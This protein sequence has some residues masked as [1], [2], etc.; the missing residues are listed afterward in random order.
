MTQIY[1]D[2]NNPN[3]GIEMSPNVVYSAQQPSE[4]NMKKNQVYGLG[5]G[6]QE[7]KWKDVAIASYFIIIQVL[8]FS[9]V[10]SYS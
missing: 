2:I 5:K 6:E 4:I 3:N 9:S 8:H 7:D 10:Y 1:E